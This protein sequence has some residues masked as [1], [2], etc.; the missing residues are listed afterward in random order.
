MEC[1]ILDVLKFEL[2]VDSPLNYTEHLLVAA[3]ACDSA[4]ELCAYLI[5]LTTVDAEV[6]TLAPIHSVAC[7]TLTPVAP[8][9]G[10][11]WGIV[12]VSHMLGTLGGCRFTSAQT[13]KLLRRPP[14]SSRSTRCMNQPS[15]LDSQWH[16]PIAPSTS[17]KSQ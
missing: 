9:S 11:R 12:G 14:W 8:C 16:W 17:Q 1:A 15:H 10:C 5:M 6:P 4:R 13:R 3:D 2:R 7:F